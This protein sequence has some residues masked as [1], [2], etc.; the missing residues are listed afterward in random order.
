MFVAIFLVFITLIKPSFALDSPQLSV[1]TSG[2]NLSMSWTTVQ[3]ASGYTLYYA[4]YPYNAQTGISNIDMG[5]TTSFSADLW[6]GA[7]FYVAVTATNGLEVSA[8]SNIELFQMSTS[9]KWSANDVKGLDPWGD[10]NGD[11]KDIIALYHKQDS[12]YLYFRV[13]LMNLASTGDQDVYIAI[14]Y[15]DGGNTALVSGSANSGFAADIAWDALLRTSA[16]STQEFFDTSYQKQA[17]VIKS[18]IYESQVDYVEFAILKSAL[19][20]WNGQAFK[21][22]AIAADTGTALAV[23]KTE[24]VLSNADTSNKRAKVILKTANMLNLYSPVG[25]DLYDG[26]Y[27]TPSDRAG[28]YTGDKYLFKAIEKYQTPLMLEHLY[29]MLPGDDFFTID[30][31][32]ISLIGK[33]LLEIPDTLGYG[34]FLPMQPDA[35]DAVAIEMGKKFRKQMGYPSSSIFYPYDG[36]LTAGD[37]QVIKNAGYK[38]IWG[39]DRFHFI[40]GGWIT[41]YSNFAANKAFVES[42]K[43]VHKIN[44]IIFLF[45]TELSN[46]NGFALDE[47]SEFPYDFPNDME[48]YYGTDKGIHI[49]NRR[50]LVDLANDPDQEKYVTIGTDIKLTPWLYED[51]ADWYI[52]WIA[53]HPWIEATTPE[54]IL[55]KNWTP[56]DH[57]DLNLSDSE[58]L[59]KYPNPNDW[60]YNAHFWQHYY[61]GIADGRSPYI[62][63][64]TQIESYFDYLPYLRDGKLIPSGLKMGDDQTPNTIVYETIN[65]LSAAPNNEITELAWLYYFNL[66]GEQAFHGANPSDVGGN[67]SPRAKAQANFL[68]QV[69]KVIASADWS[70][71]VEKGSLSDTTQVLSLD[72]DL[73]G[74]T[75]YIIKN[76]KVFIILERYGGKIQY[77]FAHDNQYGPVQLIAPNEQLQKPWTENY[78]EGENALTYGLDTGAFLEDN[79]R[80]DLFTAIASTD[81]IIFTSSDNKITKTYTL[82]GDTVTVNYSTST[83]V[84]IQFW[85]PVSLSNKYSVNWADKLSKIDT[86]NKKGWYTSDGGYAFVTSN[87]NGGGDMYSFAD[88]PV[89]SEMKAR[90]DTSTYP[91]GHFYPLPLNYLGTYHVQ[92]NFEISLTLSGGIYTK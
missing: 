31:Y 26:F 24:S 13:D 92:G 86:D 46:N 17:D 40:F 75:E 49:L 76:N 56:I 53:Q 4:Q 67:L 55:S 61:G 91:A 42:G 19:T 68:G 3:G 82:S 25:L 21:I 9:K 14:D 32:L 43:K 47:R 72:L 28:E 85:L 36:M 5:S 45:D 18:Y 20:G 38:A 65:N 70:D 6:N 22:Q 30:E 16:G 33:G 12:Q 60:H 1:T 29:D 8:Y 83:A 90:V 15:K 58:P 63:A 35:A 88:S 66:T 74:E 59:E 51:V 62:A 10:S 80:T 2:L 89:P 11:S 77:S 69:N 48:K 84:N 7:A 27:H 23:D 78:T 50:I 44:G 87:F 52:K 81:N 34:H 37:V 71:D 64:G 54:G 57:G 73:D 39:L 41:D 79:Y